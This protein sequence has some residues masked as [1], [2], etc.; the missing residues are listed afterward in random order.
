MK[1]DARIIGRNI[2]AEADTDGFQQPVLSQQR[3]FESLAIG[4]VTLNR[5]VANQFSTLI[6]D[7]LSIQRDPEDT[8]VT[9]VVQDLTLKSFE[10]CDVFMDQANDSRVRFRTMK[11]LTWLESDNFIQWP[12]GNTS[13]RL[14]DP[15]GAPVNI[16][17]HHRMSREAGHKREER[18]RIERRRIRSS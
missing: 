16:R 9:L 13:E 6:G 1:C 11:K 2:L 5:Q 7:W 4:N 12:A 8:A 18:K 10:G 3:G 15:D 14:I 17:D